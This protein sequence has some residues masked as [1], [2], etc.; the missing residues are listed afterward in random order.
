M[1]SRRAE[2][3]AAKHRGWVSLSHLATGLRHAGPTNWLGGGDEIM[4]ICQVEK[5][6]S[7]EASR[8]CWR[9][10]SS[11]TR[12]RL[13]PVELQCDVGRAVGGLS[14]RR[15]DQRPIAPRSS[16]CAKQVGV[17]ATDIDVAARDVRRKSH[18]SLVVALLAE[19]LR[20]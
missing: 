18:L 7:V 19:T 11:R 6:A 9:L 4:T 15:G 10:T 3:L 16:S 12:G 5:G 8:I 13:V 1:M 17:F 20:K 14:R 2:A